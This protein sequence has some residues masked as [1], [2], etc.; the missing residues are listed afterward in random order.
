MGRNSQLRLSTLNE[1]SIGSYH[2]NFWVQQSMGDAVP[3]GPIKA[4]FKHNM[5][6][7]GKFQKTKK[8]NEK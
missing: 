1:K 3:L 5:K 6:W 2:R 8:M 4:F 7:Y